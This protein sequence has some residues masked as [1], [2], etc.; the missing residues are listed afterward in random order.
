MPTMRDVNRHIV[1]QQAD[2]WE[3][4]GLEL[5]LKDYYIANIS[6]DH[7]NRAMV[8]CRVMLQ[9]WLDLDPYATWAKLDD[10]IKKIKLLSTSR[11]VSTVKGGNH[12]Y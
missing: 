4:L 2:H 3:M 7:L 5:G 11:S 10:A 1:E 9:K 12:S 8:C 6:K